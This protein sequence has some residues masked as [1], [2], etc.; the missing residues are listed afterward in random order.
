MQL[1]KEFKR[2]DGSTVLIRV[3]FYEKLNREPEYECSFFHMKKRQQQFRYVICP[4]HKPDEKIVVINA[5]LF[6]CKSLYDIISKEE[7]EQ[8][9]V[10]LW[11]KMRPEAG[12]TKLETAFKE[13]VNELLK[14]CDKRLID[15]FVMIEAFK[16]SRTRN[17]GK[18]RST[19]REGMELKHYNAQKSCIIQEIEDLETILDCGDKT[20]KEK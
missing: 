5:K 10:E 9:K 8:A 14:I 19:D 20:I 11:E 12:A 16:K 2:K 6:K 4:E 3:R 17:K 15:C 13:R 1:N 7:I 18:G